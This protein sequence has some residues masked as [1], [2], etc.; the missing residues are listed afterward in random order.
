M[1][2]MMILAMMM[3]M[4]I[5]ARSAMPL[6]SS[7]NAMSYNAAK[8][9]ALFLSDKMAYEL[10]LTAAQ[11]EAVYEINLDYLMSLNGHADVFGIWWDRR[12]ADLRYVLNSWQYDKYIT[13]AHFYRPVTWKA[14]SWTLAVYSHYNRGH[15]YNDHPKVFVTYKGG[16]NHKHDRFY[17]D[18]HMA[19]P[20]VNHP[21][22][23]VHH[24]APAPAP[25][26][27]KPAAAHK[28]HKGADRHVAMNSNRGNGG[29]F[30][31]K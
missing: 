7:K 10:N 17:A 4:T 25:H 31:R 6:G 21:A 27:G 8:N 9:E 5:S 29:H 12:N 22:P 2:K 13:L 15:F 28:D 3:V 1:K 20:A 24:K 30:G 26:N 11:Y 23:A 19:K 16:N 18:R 14:G